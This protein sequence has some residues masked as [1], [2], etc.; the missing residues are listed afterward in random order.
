[1]ASGEA[2]VESAVREV[3]DAHFG[4][5]VGWT[6]QLIGDRDLAHDVATDAFVK[7]LT[8]WHSVQDPR[9]WLYTAAANQVRD[10]WRKRG[11]EA[12]AY[13]KFVAGSA[14]AVDVADSGLDPATRLSVRDAVESLPERFRLVVLLH[15]F[16]DLSVAQVAAQTGKS[17]G[18]I[19]RDL[20]DARKQLAQRLEVTR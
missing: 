15:Y 18:T 3:Y 2:A 7:L 4:R 6:T 17:E 19:K 16:A 13:E 8:H 10:H 11:R 5:L 9:A 14:R 20:H 1:M 12:S